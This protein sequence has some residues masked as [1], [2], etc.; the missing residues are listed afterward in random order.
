MGAVAASM[1]GAKLRI[2]SNRYSATSMVTRSVI[3]FLF[4]VIIIIIMCGGA[5]ACDGVATL[6]SLLILF[7]YLWF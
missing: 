1:S 6:F 5:I 2:A 7:L 4:G 3:G